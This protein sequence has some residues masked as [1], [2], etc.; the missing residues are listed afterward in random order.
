[1][2]NKRS[3]LHYLL[4]ASQVNLPIAQSVQHVHARKGAKSVAAVQAIA[5][6]DGQ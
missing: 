4:V 2:P 6:L 5:A 3:R 1:M